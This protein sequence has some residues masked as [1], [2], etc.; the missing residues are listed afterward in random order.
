MSKRW[1]V[2]VVVSSER[3][4]LWLCVDIPASASAAMNVNDLVL[5]RIMIQII[6]LILPGHYLSR[7]VSF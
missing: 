1:C 3:S 5:S 2:S 7:L 6:F 4:F